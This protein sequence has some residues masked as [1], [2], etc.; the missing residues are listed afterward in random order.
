MPGDRVAILGLT[1][2]DWT[3]AD[4]GALCAGAVVAPIY[5]TNSP[6][7]CAYVLQHSGARVVFCENAAQAAKVEQVR[8]RCPALERIVLFE[9]D[10]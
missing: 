2:A 9:D 10:R 1:S 6:V 4:C 7:E 5:H 3:L 8:D